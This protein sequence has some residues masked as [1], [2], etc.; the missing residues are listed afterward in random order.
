MHS[1][2]DKSGFVW[3]LELVLDSAKRID[4]ADYSLIY[5]KPVSFLN[6]QILAQE[7]QSRSFF[8]DVLTRDGLA[9]F[10][11]WCIVKPQADQAGVTEDE[12]ARRL[13]GQQ[14]RDAR[15]ALWEEISDFFPEKR[16][17]LSQLR[18]LYLKLHKQVQETMASV[19]GEILGSVDQQ[20]RTGLQQVLKRPVGRPGKRSS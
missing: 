5:D 14:I 17:I 9:M 13:G 20:I 16:T 10:L 3:E 6:S 18:D 19:E 7:D 8:T 15:D 11:V 2:K 1:F 4:N 12:F